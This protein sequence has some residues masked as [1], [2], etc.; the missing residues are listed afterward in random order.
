MLF[1]PVTQP[2]RGTGV[3][4]HRLLFPR[5]RIG[6]LSRDS[7]RAAFVMSSNGGRGS[8]R[9]SRLGIDMPTSRATH[10]NHASVEPGRRRSLS[11]RHT[12]GEP[13][14]RRQAI[15]ELPWPTTYR[16]PRSLSP[17]IRPFAYKPALQLTLRRVSQVRET[18]SR[19]SRASALWFIVA[20]AAPRP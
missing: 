13:T 1:L 15:H 11:G 5:G 18:G 4:T 14:R 8:V 17:T 19:E 10:G 6:L 3:A 12:L 16:T 7:T 9:Q 20:G 2:G